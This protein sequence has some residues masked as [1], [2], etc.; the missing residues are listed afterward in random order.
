MGEAL[1]THALPPASPDSLSNAGL[2][3]CKGPEGVQRVLSWG[4]PPTPSLSETRSIGSPSPSSRSASLDSHGSR[5]I[6]ISEYVMGSRATWRLSLAR[7]R[8]MLG[9][10][11][12]GSP[13]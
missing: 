5:Q 1:A 6:N 8:R 7:P 10:V 13:R 4:A 9:L 3:L 11:N 12:F 2:S